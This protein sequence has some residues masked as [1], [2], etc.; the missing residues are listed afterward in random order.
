MEARGDGKNPTYMGWLIW[1]G[2]RN[3]LK[4]QK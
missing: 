1:Q 4:R 3:F 2:G